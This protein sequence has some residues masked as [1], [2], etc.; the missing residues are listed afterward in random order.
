MTIF[1]YV[2]DN[3]IRFPIRLQDANG[4]FVF[5]GNGELVYGAD[6]PAAEEHGIRGARQNEIAP[7][8]AEAGVHNDIHV[9]NG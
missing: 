8:I 3:F 1:N 2:F 5:K 4:F 9:F 6:A 7:R